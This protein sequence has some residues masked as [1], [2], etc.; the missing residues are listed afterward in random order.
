MINIKNNK[1]VVRRINSIE[2]KEKI[3]P[4]DIIRVTR[5]QKEELINVKK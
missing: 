2:N 1:L 4:G 5:H 3:N